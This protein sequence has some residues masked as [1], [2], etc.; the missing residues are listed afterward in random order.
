MN[1]AQFFESKSILLT[2]ATGFLGKVVLEKI[3]RSLP[4][5]KTVYVLL[6]PKKSI[7]I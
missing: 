1:F 7:T 6:R 2:G 5:F 3:L 4:N